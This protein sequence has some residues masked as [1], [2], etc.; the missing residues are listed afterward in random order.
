MRWQKNG[1][2]GFAKGGLVC[3]A[4]PNVPF[5][6]VGFLGHFSVVCCCSVGRHRVAANVL[7]IGEGTAFEKRQPNVSTKV[8][9][10]TNAQL[11]PSAVLLPIPCYV[12]FFFSFVTSFAFSFAS[13]IV[14]MLPLLNFKKSLSIPSLNIIPFVGIRDSM[15]KLFCPFISPAVIPV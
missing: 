14:A 12:P 2:F 5:C 6:A 10:S 8:D 3:R 15:T 13:P 9:R 4:K 1:S 7:G 11:L